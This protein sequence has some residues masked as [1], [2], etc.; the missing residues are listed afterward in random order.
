MRARPDAL[1]RP[2]RSRRLAQSPAQR[3]LI[4]TVALMA[5]NR[6]E[7]ALDPALTGALLGS[8]YFHAGFRAFADPE[9]AALYRLTPTPPL[10][11]GDTVQWPAR[12]ARTRRLRQK[13]PSLRPFG[14]WRDFVQQRR[15]PRLSRPYTVQS[16]S[17][18]QLELRSPR[19]ARVTFTIERSGN[20]HHAV[21]WIESNLPARMIRLLL[22]YL[23]A[24]GRDW[25]HFL[26][27]G[28]QPL[29]TDPH[30]EWVRERRGLGKRPGELTESTVEHCGFQTLLL[31]RH[32]A[33]TDERD[34]TWTEVASANGVAISPS[35]MWWDLSVTDGNPPPQD[36]YDARDDRFGT[37]LEGAEGLVEIEA[38]FE[39]LASHTSTPEVSF[40][41]V[42]DTSGFAW[43]RY[44]PG[45]DHSVTY[46]STD[47]TAAIHPEFTVVPASQI[48][49]PEVELEREMRVLQT[50][51]TEIPAMTGLASGRFRGVDALWPD[52][53]EWLLLTD[54]DWAHSLLGCDRATADAIRTADGIEAV[55]LT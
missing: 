41:A 52:G 14:T 37:P 47:P 21:I 36:P 2:T 33:R 26:R 43:H 39:V 8:P 5:T 16:R 28:I 17:P 22:A 7:I 45:P 29:T 24:E 46:Y 4:A 40:G 34:V 3:R 30:L 19:G 31:V 49:S 48:C 1:T 44:G 20:A 32:P 51:V 18:M 38:L 42:F 9:A 10:R 11:A 6:I 54:I 25:Q 15:R 50:K 53:R 55:E 13:P 35:S 23:E 27:C 12:D